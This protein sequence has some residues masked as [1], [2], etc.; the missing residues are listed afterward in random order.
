LESRLE[1][2]P[3]TALIFYADFGIFDPANPVEGRGVSTL[4]SNPFSVLVGLIGQVTRTLSAEVR[5]G[6]GETLVWNRTPDG[7]L[8]RFEETAR[9]NQRTVIGL[10]SLTWRFLRTANLSLTYQRSIQPTVALSSLI[11]DA[12]R[13]RVNW[14]IDRL[15]L[16]AY[17]EGQLRE[18]GFQVD[19]TDPGEEPT[20]DVEREPFA[21]LAFGGVK[22]EYYF[23][24]WLVGGLNYRIMYQSSNDEDRQ[25]PGG[26]VLPA[27]GE[28]TR[29][30]VF[31]LVSARY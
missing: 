19:T 20:Q 15:V 17:A 4:G 28:F 18:F 21:V 23:L 3:K 31:A 12:V 30:Q 2:L 8:Q 25:T 11:A 9:T 7:E 24:D 1:F 14:G 29:H 13:F 6:Y 27:L 5:A 10:A 22:A 16:G 26:T